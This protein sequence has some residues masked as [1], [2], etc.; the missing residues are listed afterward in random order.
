MSFKPFAWIIGVQRRAC[1]IKIYGFVLL[2]FSFGSELPWNADTVIE[3]TDVDT[4]M[5]TYKVRKDMIEKDWPK[6]PI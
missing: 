5:N 3:T 1:I 2:S 6:S 4:F